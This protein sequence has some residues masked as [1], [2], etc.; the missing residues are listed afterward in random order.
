MAAR[1]HRILS[2]LVVAFHTLCAVVLVVLGYLLIRSNGVRDDFYFPLTREDQRA[3]C[4]YMMSLNGFAMLVLELDH[5]ATPALGVRNAQYHS[6]SF[7]K[8]YRWQFLLWPSISMSSN[9]TNRSTAL[10]VGYPLMM[11][12]VV[13]PLVGTASVDFF[14]WRRRSMQ[15]QCVRCGYDLRAS[16]ERCPECGNEATT[17]YRANRPTLG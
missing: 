12:V 2:R 9:A 14:R 8:G 5:S 11:I 7:P 6:M 13:L 16:P 15:G 1:P 10:R 17:V 4:F 3:S